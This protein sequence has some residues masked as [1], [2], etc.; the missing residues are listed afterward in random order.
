[1]IS[2]KPNLLATDPPMVAIF[3]NWTPRISL[4]PRTTAPPQKRCNGSNRS[5]SPCV[6][7]APITNSLS[8]S[9]TYR[10]SSP[11]ISITAGHV[12]RPKRSQHPPASIGAVLFFTAIS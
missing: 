4:T 1:M 11:A 2:E 5:T 12:R 10:K 7:M 6:A 8:S 9:R 3:L